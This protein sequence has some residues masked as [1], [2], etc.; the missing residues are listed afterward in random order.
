MYTYERTRVLLMKIGSA[1]Q[2]LCIRLHV[3][4][5]MR[6]NDGII[7]YNS[8]RT[9]NMSVYDTINVHSAN[10]KNCTRFFRS[11]TIYEILF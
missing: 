1:V 8:Y 4:T 9:H 2:T 3:T 7:F 5:M 6:R 10:Y 11:N